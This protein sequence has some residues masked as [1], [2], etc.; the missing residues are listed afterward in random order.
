MNQTKSTD[1]EQNIREVLYIIIP[2]Y[3]E[4]A[5]INQCID[6]WYPIV[7]SHSGGGK[8]RLVIINDGSKD[9]TYEVM[10]ERAKTL[11]LFQPLTKPNGGHGPTLLYGYRYAIA[12]GAN[13]IFQTDS[14]GQTSPVE[15]EQFWVLRNEYAA[16]FGNRT[17]RGDGKDRAFVE[18]TLCRILKHYFKVNVPDANA[19]FRLMR[20]DYVGKYIPKLKEDYNLPNAMLV[21]FGDYYH[22]AIKFIP[23]SFKPRQAGTNSINVKKIVRIGWQALR[24]FKEIQRG[25]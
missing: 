9:K 19:P 10:R 24:D 18:K 11:P 8:S 25:M 5:N 13:Y 16:I 1:K 14:D 15:F 6:D 17:E 23:I 7:E 20:S 2:A 4:E 3:N 12:N 22:E 21:A